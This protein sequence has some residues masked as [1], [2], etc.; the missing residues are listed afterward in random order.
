[1]SHISVLLFFHLNASSLHDLNQTSNYQSSLIMKCM[2]QLTLLTVPTGSELE[3]SELTQ[4]L[5]KNM[6][7]NNKTNIKNIFKWTTFLLVDLSDKNALGIVM[8]SHGLPKAQWVSSPL[9]SLTLLGITMPKLGLYHW[10]WILSAGRADPDLQCPRGQNSSMPR[11]RE[12]EPSVH[13]LQ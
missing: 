9:P 2:H 5:N 10:G 1:M 13:S 4:R 3:Y 7:I 6:S 8:S 12:T 11:D